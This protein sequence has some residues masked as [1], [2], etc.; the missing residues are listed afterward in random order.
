[1]ALQCQMFNYKMILCDRMDIIT[2]EIHWS[3]SYQYHDCCK[4]LWWIKCCAS[5]YLQ[6]C[7]AVDRVVGC[8]RSKRQ[9]CSRQSSSSNKFVQWCFF[10]RHHDARFVMPHCRMLCVPMV[11]PQPFCTMAC[12]G[13]SH[14]CQYRG[15]LWS[16]RTTLLDDYLDRGS[17]TI[18]SVC[19]GL[20]CSML[21]WV[22]VR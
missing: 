17:T 15:V 19:V 10:W 8:R 21:E 1:M 7:S 20:L 13:T 6:R 2:A 4:V 5:V 3:V 18:T 11:V 14:T 9:R 12:V 16:I 22:L